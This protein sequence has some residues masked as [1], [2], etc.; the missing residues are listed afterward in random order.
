MEYSLKARQHRKKK[1]KKENPQTK[2]IEY[3]R[4]VI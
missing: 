2:K 4:K 3:R 1:E